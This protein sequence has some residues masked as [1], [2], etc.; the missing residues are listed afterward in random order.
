MFMLWLLDNYER[1]IIGHYCEYMDHAEVLEEATQP[2]LLKSELLL[3]PPETV[4]VTK[5][6][7]PTSI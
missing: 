2:G 6:D 4:T 5:A 1:A 7:A 3:D